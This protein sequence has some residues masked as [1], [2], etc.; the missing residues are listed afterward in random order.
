MQIYISIVE[1]FLVAI[2]LAILILE[3]FLSLNNIE[4]DTISGI[5]NKWA[6]GRNFFI[7]FAWG[8]VTGHLFLGAKN[9]L[10]KDNI[11]SVLVVVLLVCITVIIGCTRKSPKVTWVVQVIL[12][13]SGAI[14]GHFTWS[15]NDF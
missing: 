6:Y 3:V 7:T 4:G 9:P 15:M 10:L 14:I 8:I 13:I 5:I 1:V 2:T 12:L 11:M